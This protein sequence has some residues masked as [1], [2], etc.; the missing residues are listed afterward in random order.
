[1][2]HGSPYWGNVYT[3]DTLGA[4]YEL[5]LSYD[6]RDAYGRSDWRRFHGLDGIYLANQLQN[7]VGTGQGDATLTRIT[8]NQGGEWRALPQPV[9]SNGNTI[10]CDVDNCQLNLHL[11][12][13]RNSGYQDDGDIF[14][15]VLTHGRAIGLIIAT[16]N[17]GNDLSQTLTDVNT[18]FSRDAGWTWVQIRNGSYVYEFAD[19]GA[20]WL[21]AN[22]IDATDTFFYTWNEG[23]TFSECSFT[24]DGPV[25][26]LNIIVD[27][28]ALSST[29]VIHGYRNVDG[30]DIGY[31][32]TI[33]FSSFH[34]RQCT[35]NDY[36]Y[37]SPSDDRN[38]TQS[39]C[40]LG[41]STTYTRR[42][43]TSE[44]FNGDTYEIEVQGKTCPCDRDDYECDYCYEDIGGHCSKVQD[45][46]PDP[47][48]CNNGY[49]SVSR[50]YRI[51][52]GDQ[53]NISTGLD[54]TP[55]QFACTSSSGV[56]GSSSDAIPSSHKISAGIIVL[57]LFFILLVIGVI[58]GGLYYLN[59]KK[60]L[61]GNLPNTWKWDKLRGDNT[62]TALD[63]D[64]LE[65]REAQTL[66]DH[67]IEQ[68]LESKP[69]ETDAT[70]INL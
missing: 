17:I 39:N 52:A 11:T 63:E 40:L 51:V 46:V 32:A 43:R 10:D 60:N 69:K 13:K 7:V 66:D 12:G 37:W 24:R 21:F 61:M 65:A 56:I 31:L 33:D 25:E 42:K 3:S 55:Q 38:D 67:E 29:F 4:E 23:L 35:T 53:C 34:E 26:I 70:L 41:Q 9:D 27:P 19:H 57:I 16:G 8:Y 50:G 15:P 44:C 22:N 20:I 64:L 6:R 5:S 36:E 2:R 14:G 48:T 30:D 54:L 18:Y 28:S 59:K 58:V 1:V 47:P 45:C 49:Y 68:K 62:S